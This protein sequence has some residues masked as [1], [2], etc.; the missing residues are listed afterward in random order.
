MAS[1]W[2]YVEGKDRVGPISEDEL[3]SRI[4]EGKLGD[5]SYVWKKG[6]ENWKKISDLDELKVVS[7]L[8]PDPSPA[9][10]IRHKATQETEIETDA[11]TETET[12]KVQPEDTPSLL[13]PS[14][15]D[16]QNLDHKRRIFTVKIGPDRGLNFEQEYGP[17][18]ANELKRAFEENRINA[19]TLVYAPGMDEWSFLADLP[20]FEG[21]MGEL[22]PVISESERRKNKRRPFTARMLFS[23][24]S[25]VYEGICRDISVGG[26]QVMI[27]DPQVGPGETISLNVH[28]DNSDYCFVASGKIVRILEGRQGMSLRFTKLNEEARQAIER[29]VAESG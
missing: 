12:E 4:S 27:A 22:P 18:N 2:Y 21:L 29:Y 20:L 6:L 13:H 15:I 5:S 23:G 19:K 26:M 11:E 17:F 10:E 14:S 8:T 1:V 3:L 25:D 9:H 24:K 16:W 28:P 7:T